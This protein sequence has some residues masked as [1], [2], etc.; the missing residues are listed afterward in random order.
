MDGRRGGPDSTVGQNRQKQKY[1][2]IGERSKPCGGLV[3]GPGPTE[4]CWQQC[5]MKSEA[6][7][8]S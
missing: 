8:F 4:K 5:E 1:E 7:P 2:K 3:P 6:F